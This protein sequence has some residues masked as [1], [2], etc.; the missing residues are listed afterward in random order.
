MSLLAAMIAE[1]IVPRKR[2][3]DDRYWEPALGRFHRENVSWIG[4]ELGLQL[5]ARCVSTDDGVSYSATRMADV[6]TP[7]SAGWSRTCAWMRRASSAFR[8]LQSAP[9]PNSASA[10]ARPANARS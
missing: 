5:A 8:L 9:P 7:G 10:A 3:G 1:M 2:A 4:W 6:P